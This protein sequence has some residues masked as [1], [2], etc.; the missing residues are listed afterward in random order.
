MRIVY[1]AFLLAV[2]ASVVARGDIVLTTNVHAQPQLPQGPFVRTAEGV[3]I[4]V[5]LKAA[6]HS[7][8]EGQTWLEQPLFDPT[9]FE[10]SGKRALLRTTEG[11]IVYAF[12]NRKEL[13]FKWDD[14]KGGPQEGCRLPVYVMRS[15]DDG[16]T[17]SVPALLQEGWCGAVRQM[18]QLKSGRI[19]LVSQQAAANPGR[20]V[21]WIYVSDD[22]GQ[23]WQKSDPI[24]FGERGNYGAPVAGLSGVTHGGA[25]EGT[26]IEKENGDLKLLLRLPHGYFH[27]L[28]SRGGLKWGPGTPSTLEA[29]DSPGTMVRLASGRVALVWNRYR[30]PSTRQGRREE[31]SLAFSSNDGLTW[32]VP[33]VIA[34]NPMPAGARESAHWLAYPYIFESSLGRLWITT[35]QGGLR[36]A[37]NEND[38][39]TPNI[40]PATAPLAERTVRILALGDSITKG[41]RPNVAPTQI[42]SA[43]LQAGLRAHGLRAEVHNVGIGGER[44]DQALERLAREVISQRPDLVTMMYGTND[45]WVDAGK[46]ESRLSI[47]QFTDNLRRLVTRLS[48]ANIRVVLM[49]APRFGDKNP[50]NGLGEDPN[51]RLAPFMERC[52]QVAREAQVPFVDHF[53]AW[54]QAEARGQRVQDWTTDGCH[55]N[56]LGHAELAPRVIT[57]VEPLVRA[58]LSS[59]ARS[60]R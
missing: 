49:T 34:R 31:L 33:Q 45:S 57:V 60:A 54:T 1:L 48:E 44:T 24:D 46:K 21:T 25:I 19:V 52:R 37:L 28:T 16:K 59:S 14:K 7:R 30:E 58:L 41:A 13:D 22:L 23:T 8:D 39:L 29:S 38:F 43:L 26:L 15:A 36:V 50:R 56:P 10:S 4:G 55:P 6:L 35:M 9:K 18:I 12:L 32:T 51:V 27:E 5:G 2:Y 53:D 3:I 11:V 42:F 17:W 47:E 20:H 40:S